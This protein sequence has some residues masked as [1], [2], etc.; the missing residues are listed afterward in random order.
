MDKEEQID[1]WQDILIDVLYQACGRT[2]ADVIDD[3]AISSYEEACDQLVMCG[4]L[5]RL[6]GRL[7]KIISKRLRKWE[8]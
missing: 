3:Q 1:I 2:G 5:E 7:Y 6:G 4:K 8:Y